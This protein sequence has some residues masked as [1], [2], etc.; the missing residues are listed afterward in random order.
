[1][2]YGKCEACKK[3]KFFVNRQQ[4]YVDVL[5]QT[6]LSKKIMCRA[7]INKVKQAVDGQLQP[8]NES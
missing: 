8:R 2:L 7:C 6:I 5:K 3:N 1:M 4:I